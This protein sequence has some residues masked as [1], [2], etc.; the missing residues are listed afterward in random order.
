MR[1]GEYE[2]N[3]HIAPASLRGRALKEKYF[4]KPLK[5]VDYHIRTS[6]YINLYLFRHKA[7]LNRKIHVFINYKL[8][9]VVAVYCPEYFTHKLLTTGYRLRGIFCNIKIILL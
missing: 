8:L 3:L 4:K 7:I 5:P 2:A 6:I 9:L 1:R